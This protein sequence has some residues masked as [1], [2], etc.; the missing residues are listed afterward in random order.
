MAVGTIILPNVKIASNII[1][2]AESIVSKTIS[3]GVYVGIPCQR[4]CS[5]EEYFEQ[6]KMTMQSLSCYNEKW[7]YINITNQMKYE[8]KQTVKISGWGYVI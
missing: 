2:G 7:T 3:S 4:I 1:I 5:Y 8:M 6:Y